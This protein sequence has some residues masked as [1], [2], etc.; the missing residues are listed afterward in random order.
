[1][2]TRGYP[3]TRTATPINPEPWG[4][5]FE[6]TMEDKITD[7]ID[8]E[9]EERIEA[10]RLFEIAGQCYEHNDRDNGDATVSRAYAAAHRAECYRLNRMKLERG[11]GE[12]VH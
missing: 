4:A 8:E 10:A 6:D 1:M 9:I 3:A 12:S 5:F 7:L 11:A 2:K